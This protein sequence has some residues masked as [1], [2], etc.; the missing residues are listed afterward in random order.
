MKR[1]ISSIFLTFV[2]L[3]WCLVPAGAQDSR[4]RTVLTVVQDALAQLPALT[5]DDLDREMEDIAMAAP[6]SVEILAGMLVPASE[7][8]NSPVEYAISGL[9]NFVSASGNEKYSA[10]V[11][12]GLAA[13]LGRCTDIP[14]KSFLLAQLRLLA[15]REDIP[16]FLEYADDE[17]LGS[18][19]V[20]A[21]IS[22]PESDE[23]IL[24]LIR[25]EGASRPLLAYAA[26]EKGLSEAEPY[27]MAWIEELD[28]NTEEDSDPSSKADTPDM[29]TYLHA[30]ACCGGEESLDVLRKASVYDYITLLDRLAGQGNTAAAV[31]G[32]KKLL[33]SDDT[34]IRCAALELLVRITG[35]GADK[36]V[37]DAVKGRD[38]EYRCAALRYAAG[39]VDGSAVADSLKKIFPGISDVSGDYDVIISVKSGKKD[40]KSFKYPSERNPLIVDGIR[41][42][43]PSL[44][45]EARTDVVNWA[46]DNRITGLL[47]EVLRCIPAARVPDKIES[48]AA[49]SVAAI[50]AAGK[51]GGEYAADA[52]VCQLSGDADYARVAYDALLSF[53]G[54]IQERL[55]RVLDDGGNAVQYALDLACARRMTGLALQ[56]FSLLDSGDSM[57]RRAAYQALKGV[58]TPQDCS[59]L[60]ELMETAGSDFRVSA[61]QDALCHALQS[62]P[63]EVQYADVKSLIEKS[64][65]P[66][67]YYPALAQAGTKEAVAF[68]K[69]AYAEGRGTE[70]AFSALMAVGNPAAA[71]VLMDI[72]S[73]DAGRAETALVRVVDLVSGS[74][75]DDMSRTAKYAAVLK[76]SREAALQ[77]KVLDA[78]SGTPVMPAFLLAARYL[79]DNGTAY[80]A[81]GAVK[82]IAAQT[83]DEIDYAAMKSALEKA[84]RIFS[85]AGGADDG[86]AVD[87]IKKMLSELQ[88]PAEKFVLPEDEAKAGYEVLFDGTDLSKWTGDMEG[89]TPVNG[90][91]FVTANYGDSRN[92]YTKKEYRDFI[93]RFEF[94]FVKPGVNNGVGIRTPMGKDAAYWGMCESQILDHDDPIY[95][96]LHEYQVHGSAYGIIPAKRIVHKPLGEWNFEEIKVV[97]DRITV[98]LNGEVILD[99]NLREACQGHNV[100]PDGSSYNPYTVDHKNHPGMFNEKGHIGFLGH[101]AGIKFRNVRILDLDK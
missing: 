48:S 11:K 74:G 32:A 49:L 76:V 60:G 22:I 50:R 39:I 90:T 100:A 6:E 72:A 71:D 94:C 19:A 97:G 46:G 26:A 96:G 14:C 54:D 92:L 31:A 12:A 81:A 73:K 83:T 67:L 9:V 93:F 91:I 2:L 59:R 87:E 3:A 20:N 58:V 68:L 36:Y 42:L 43:F 30:L 55:G 41:K 34:Y 44:S 62:L 24:W 4:Q 1:I 98:T 89:Y 82:A 99:G 57:V 27:L 23:A 69:D 17:N 45:D 7:G 8:Q 65:N 37:L 5:A 40:E 95:N 13:G 38:R 53:D 25:S 66:A 16:V 101:G 18:V 84:A 52:L 86:Y 28:G 35:A 70:A 80:K 21:L 88:P 77:N 47:E 51:L 79:D 75:M 10:P 78:L 61:L 85:A 56:V 63:G 33:K 29:R 64:G 15:D